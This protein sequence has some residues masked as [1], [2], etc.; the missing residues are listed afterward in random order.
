MAIPDYQTLMLPLLELAEDQKEHNIKDAVNILS[1][2]YNL[3]EQER[4]E[5]KS[6]HF[7]RMLIFLLIAMIYFM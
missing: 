2:K 4:T 1:E 5:P 3:T 7:I 6:P